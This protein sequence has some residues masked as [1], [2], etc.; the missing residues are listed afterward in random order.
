MN[1]NQ[2]FINGWGLEISM[3]VWELK[4]G[5]VSNVQTSCNIH[6]AGL[7]LKPAECEFFQHGVEFLEYTVSRDGIQAGLQ[8][9]E[10]P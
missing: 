5:I 8:K 9:I 4:N 6:E 3:Q 1:V 10:M 2:R 7:K